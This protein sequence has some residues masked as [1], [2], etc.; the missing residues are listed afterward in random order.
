MI[1]INSKFLL[2]S[3]TERKWIFKGL[4]IKQKR[5]TVLHAH[6]LVLFSRHLMIHLIWFGLINWNDYSLDYHRCLTY[7][8]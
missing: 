2:K 4:R 7:Q 3:K 5:H 8:L 1:Q 6:L